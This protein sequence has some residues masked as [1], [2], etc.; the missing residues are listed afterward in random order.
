MRRSLLM[1]FAAFLIGC[2]SGFDESQGA[3]TETQNPTKQRSGYFNKDVTLGDDVVSITD[4]YGE[5]V[6]GYKLT[7]E[8]SYTIQYTDGKTETI[9]I[10]KTAPWISFVN[11]SATYDLY[12]N[13]PFEDSLPENAVRDEGGS[14]YDGEWHAVWKDGK[15]PTEPGEYVRVYTVYDNAGNASEP[16]MWSVVVY[17]SQGLGSLSAITI[18]PSTGF[19][20]PDDAEVYWYKDKT[21]NITLTVGEVTG[22][23]APYIYAWRK[24]N[25][26]FT[27][28][29]QTY[30]IPSDSL[31]EG[32]VSYVVKVTDAGGQIATKT[33]NI[34]F[35]QTAPVVQR[36]P[37]VLT[38][39]MTNEVRL[40]F[41]ETSALLK[42]IEIHSG[43]ATIQGSWKDNPAKIDMFTPYE[44]TVTVT[45]NAGNTS[46]AFTYTVTFQGTMQE[47]DEAAMTGTA[48]AVSTD[49][50][51]LPSQ[52][53]IDWMAMGQYAFIHWGP[54]AFSNAEW[55]N[56]YPAGANSF[57]PTRSADVITQE[58]ID[59]IV[60]AGMTGLIFVAKH[61]DGFCLW[62]T[63]TTEYSVCKSGEGYSYYN[64]DILVAL[65]QNMK[66]YNLSHPGQEL[67]LGVYV[68]PWD[69]NHWTYGAEDEGKYPYL[70]YVLR[71]Q[72]TEV[73]EC[74]ETV[75]EGHVTMFELWLDGANTP[76]GW[77][78]GKTYAQH[79]A[80]GASVS[81]TVLDNGR[82][83]VDSF[84]Q[85]YDWAGK[86]N[87]QNPSHSNVSLPSDWRNRI[88][89]MAQEVVD[90]Y[91]PAEIMIFG[92]QIRWVGNEQG[93]AGRTNW[94]TVSKGLADNLCMYGSEEGDIVRPA[95]AD[96]KTQNGWFYTPNED[97][98]SAKMIEFWYRS[99]GRN[100]TLLLNFSPDTTGKIPSNN[101]SS[102]QTMWKTI[103]SDF[104][105]NLAGKVFRVTA[106]NTRDNALDY[107]Q[108]NVIDG[109]YE[110]YWSVDD[111]RTEGNEWIQLTF[112]E[113]VSFN[114]IVLQENIAL[115]QRV[116]E[117]K[118][119]YSDNGTTWQT[120]TYPNMPTS[121][122]G[123]TNNPDVTT[124]IGFKRIL[125]S[126][127]V[128]ANHV[129]VTFTN[130]RNDT[131][132]PV[133]LSELGIYLAK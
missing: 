49:G 35:D 55:G 60:T 89:S 8:G 36:A 98:G 66:E 54:N 25:E 3:F 11:S 101:L 67:K 7:E 117:F 20:K 15:E 108:Y 106:S 77:Y 75:G 37:K 61:H 81:V 105:E 130:Y 12:T 97:K 102:A 43:V 133:A 79:K 62:D 122:S 84:R 118:V 74:V 29:E 91:E 90:S 17:D 107:S 45:D 58:W 63:V 47:E 88:Y 86:V 115:G 19:Q 99:T 83:D 59:D 10:D 52:A 85:T 72:I 22:G 44:R 40:A 51:P 111:N 110:T 5:V 57:R 127:T 27:A 33:I 41:Q 124:T 38:G 18:T 21:S 131:R 95:E 128:R 50:F 114:R 6:I 112:S 82:A 125:R 92:T 34:G 4:Q 48:T 31:T 93:W 96:M 71:T 42:I 123:D 1:I 69:R 103:S 126:D 100:G 13:T 14:G 129:R 73:I 119:E 132:V 80:D 30:A 46:A 32:V 24:G 56:G 120:V 28:G 76:S 121:I 78:G 39:Y 109:D 64:E 116:K 53:Q 94:I 65:V 104:A 68:S 2:P 87:V 26:D 9:V 70:E 23:T 113:P 16:Y